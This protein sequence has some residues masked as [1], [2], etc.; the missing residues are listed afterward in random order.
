MLEIMYPND[1]CTVVEQLDYDPEID[2]Q[3]PLGTKREWQRGKCSRSEIRGGSTVVEQQNYNP[4]IK[5]SNPGAAQY[6]GKMAE[7]NG[8]STVVEQLANKPEIGG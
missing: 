8:S 2:G 6:H 3:K 7:H 4:E 5:G 1:I